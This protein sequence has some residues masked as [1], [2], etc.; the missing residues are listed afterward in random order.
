MH[1]VVLIQIRELEM[2][3]N[4]FLVKLNDLLSIVV[5]YLPILTSHTYVCFPVVWT[6]PSDPHVLEISTYHNLS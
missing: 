5:I 4:H 3:Q 6:K 2:K 1:F